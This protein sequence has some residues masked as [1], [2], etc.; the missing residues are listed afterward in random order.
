LNPDPA[1]NCHP[2]VSP[3]G[4]FINVCVVPR[5][6]VTTGIPLV[7]IYWGI[8]KIPLVSF[9]K[10]KQAIASSMAKLQN[11]VLEHMALHQRGTAAFSARTLHHQPSRTPSQCVTSAAQLRPQPRHCINGTT[12]PSANDATLQPCAAYERRRRRMVTKHDNYIS[13]NKS[14]QTPKLE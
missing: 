12:M 8:L 7:S 14:S 10:N 6:D 9:A 1:I 13:F 2:G 3:A 5:K 4:R 11:P